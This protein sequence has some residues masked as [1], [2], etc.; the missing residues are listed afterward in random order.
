MYSISS[1][2]VCMYVTEVEPQIS[3]FHL[4]I[5]FMSRGRVG[6]RTAGKDCERAKAAR[7][8]KSKQKHKEKMKIFVFCCLILLESICNGKLEGKIDLKPQRTSFDKVF[9]GKMNNLE[10]ISQKIPYWVSCKFKS[11]DI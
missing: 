7:F 10:K 8:R 11:Y 5:F 9:H 1:K 4:F 3:R 2:Y 6:A